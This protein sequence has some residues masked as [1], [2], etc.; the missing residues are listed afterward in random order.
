[1]INAW[2]RV[3]RI[4][5]FGIAAVAS[6]GALV[7][8]PLSATAAPS[9]STDPL[10]QLSTDGVNFSASVAPLFD[11]SLRMI[12]ESAQ[13]R[14]LWVMNASTE[15]GYLRVVVGGVTGNNRELLNAL[16]LQADTEAMTGSSVSLTSANPC[17]VLTE[18][19]LLGP[20]GTMRVDL[21]LLLGDMNGSH[22]QGGNIGF[23]LLVGLSGVDPAGTP[24]TAC[25]SAGTA[26]QVLPA[27]GG[28][29][30]TSAGAAGIADT[31][32]VPDTTDV[33]ETVPTLADLV[34]NTARLFQENFV[35]L[36]V[37][38][39][40]LGAFLMLYLTRRRRRADEK[41]GVI[42]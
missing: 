37:V 5:M 30:S 20:G 38:G 28:P 32:D 33:P 16:S 10:V 27:A 1:M 26:V 2:V 40:A 13:S 11:T 15:E 29:G 34:A 31:A 7:L 39:A 36:W 35:F 14:S 41:N 18:G 8:A 22:G 3:R 6:V 19:A 21:S 24:A 42:S 4:A 9:T 25:I 12:P 23:Q 17:H